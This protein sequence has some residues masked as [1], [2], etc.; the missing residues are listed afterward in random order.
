MRTWC[1]SCH[2]L[3]AWA[4]HIVAAAH[5]QLVRLSFIS[6]SSPIN[7]QKRKQHVTTAITKTNEHNHTLRR[8][9][10]SFLHDTAC[11]WQ[12]L[13]LT[14]YNV[15]NYTNLHLLKCILQT[16]GVNLGITLI[17][18]LHNTNK[19]VNNFLRLLI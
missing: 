5:L 18:H 13:W 2:N 17:V 16:R 15:I 9:Y 6:G 11:T 4:W 10:Y 12:I 14:G 19:V 7:M 8:M 1:I 3:Q